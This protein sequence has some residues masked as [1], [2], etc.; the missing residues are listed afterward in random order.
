MGCEKLDRK[1]PDRLGKL[2]RV[3]GY[4]RLRRQMRSSENSSQTMD[5]TN[6]PAGMYHLGVDARD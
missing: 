4:A 5:Q 3:A 6:L 1:Q 2:F